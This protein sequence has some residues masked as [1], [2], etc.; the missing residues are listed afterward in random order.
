ML[1]LSATNG[2]TS[3]SSDLNS[4]S[5][6]GLIQQCTVVKDHSIF[7]LLVELQDGKKA[8]AHVCKNDD[9]TQLLRCF[10]LQP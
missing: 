8:F 9:F 6:I 10:I 7:G 1:G 3:L 4:D 5:S 2:I